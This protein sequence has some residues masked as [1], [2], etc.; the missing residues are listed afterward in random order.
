V[1]PGPGA[2]QSGVSDD[3]YIYIYIY[4]YIINKQILVGCLAQ[5]S[6]SGESSEA[7]AVPSLFR[8][9]LFRFVLAL[10]PSRIPSLGPGVLEILLRG[11]RW[12]PG[13]S[14]PSIAPVPVLRLDFFFVSGFFFPS[15]S[16]GG[17]WW[18]GWARCG[19]WP[20]CRFVKGVSCVRGQPQWTVVVL[21]GPRFSLSLPAPRE[22]WALDSPP[23]P[24]SRPPPRRTP[25]RWMRVWCA[26]REPLLSVVVSA[27]AAAA[28]VFLL[29]LIV[30]E[31]C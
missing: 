7:Q 6:L 10:S 2:R 1:S 20:G 27:T 9:F 23:P 19:L 8:L 29:E 17:G 5:P 3:L 18:W 16:G 26:V 15:G 12:G 31:I 24:R 21:W 4:I 25:V 14:R 13:R 11:G 30:L 28:A 22:R